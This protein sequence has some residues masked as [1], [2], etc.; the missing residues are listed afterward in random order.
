MPD[1]TLLQVHTEVVETRQELR[2]HQKGE[3]ELAAIVKSN[4]KT[5]QVIMSHLE[6]IDIT[7]HAEHHRFILSKIQR[8]E[9]AAQFWS[10]Q[11]SKLATA[12]IIGT[13]TVLTTS[14]W[15]LI[16]FYL[17]NGPGGH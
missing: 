8:E 9:E 5:L 15:F 14:V 4:D 6:H 17:A 10:E 12:G 2:D 11:R 1:I 13:V 16:K 3:E 7:T